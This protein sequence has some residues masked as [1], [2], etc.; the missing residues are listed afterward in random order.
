MS[1]EA[2]QNQ[3]VQFYNGV[4]AIITEQTKGIKEQYPIL[5]QLDTRIS[6][7]VL[8]LISLCVAPLATG[9]GICMSFFGVERYPNLLKNV[10]EI[11]AVAVV[12]LKVIAAAIAALLFY[13]YATVLLPLGIGMTAGVLLASANDRMAR[14][15]VV[16]EALAEVK[17]EGNAEGVLPKGA[18][19]PK[20]EDLYD[21]G[22]TPKE[23]LELSKDAQVPMAENNEELQAFDEDDLY[24]AILPQAEELPKAALQEAKGNF[25]VLPAGKKG[26]LNAAK[27]D[28]NAGIPKVDF[29]Q[30]KIFPLQENFQPIPQ[31]PCP[32]IFPPTYAPQKEVPESNAKVLKP[33]E[34][35]Q[36]KAAVVLP[37]AK[38]QNPA[39]VPND[40]K[41]KEE[42]EDI[43]DQAK[44]LGYDYYNWIFDYLNP[45]GLEDS[46]K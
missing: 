46:K 33:K 26:I 44:K 21:Q 16:P 40:I 7:T 19:A 27:L 22:E 39:K 25:D 38:N 41:L 30:D 37:E 32:K 34:P 36:P 17:I 10:K 4:S 20:E 23:D 31:P 15:N 13:T 6:A 43:R 8:T 18:Q 12:E 28:H 45:K 35:V 3:V 5:T 9:T 24:A 1:F 11:D 14:K 29:F 42:N 2:L